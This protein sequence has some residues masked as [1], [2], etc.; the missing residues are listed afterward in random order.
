MP[1]LDLAELALKVLSRKKVPP[2]ATYVSTT[3]IAQ[4]WRHSEGP[5]AGE[6]NTRPSLESWLPANA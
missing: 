4:A 2:V 5:A 3:E 1:N 6:V